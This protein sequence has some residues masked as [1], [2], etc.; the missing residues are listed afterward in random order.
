MII[1][2]PGAEFLYDGKTYRIGD[3]VV[4][5]WEIEYAGLIG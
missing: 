2:K 5:C 3:T 4:A 1:T